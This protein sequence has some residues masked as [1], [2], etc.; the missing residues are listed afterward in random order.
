MPAMITPFKVNDD[1]THHVSF[2]ARSDFHI[3][4]ATV[5]FYLFR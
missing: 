1:N 2:A 3:D 4:I 5:R